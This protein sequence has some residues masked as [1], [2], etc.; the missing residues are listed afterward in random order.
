MI[1]DQVHIYRLTFHETEDDA[2]VAGHTNTPLPSPIT[3][4]RMQAVARPVQIL[5]HNGMV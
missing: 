5:W 2:P 3:L 1:V 4:Q